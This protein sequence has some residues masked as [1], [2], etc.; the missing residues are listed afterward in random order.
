MSNG[1]EQRP[2]I[3]VGGIAHETHCFA[4][5]L[6]D[7]DDFRKQALFFGDDIPGQLAATK[8]ATAGMFANARAD[9]EIIPT[10]YAGALPA[11]VVTTDAFETILGEL[12]TRLSAAMPLEGVLLALHGAMVTEDE[13]DAES[14]ILAD[15]RGVVGPDVPVV[16]VLD[17]HGN[18]SPRTV[19]L[20]EVEPGSHLA[21]L[22]ARHR[23]RLAIDPEVAEEC[24]LYKRI[25]LDLVFRSR[26]L[27]QLDR[28]S[29]YILTR[30][31]GVFAELY[32]V[33]EKPGRG[34]YHLLAEEE[35]KLVFSQP[36]EASRARV[37][38]DVLAKMTDGIA[39][40]TYRRLFDAD[41]GS[42]VDL[43]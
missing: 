20:A 29:D 23:F 30:L 27:Q 26:Q 5:R 8:S 19:E 36:D 6:T 43:V 37:V 41:F 15:V 28:K 22:S 21:D 9:W 32:I 24:A 39:S 40:R 1:T 31:F 17:M 12:R 2:R 3:A 34:H 10:V 11:G 35:E 38:C 13:L 33:P 16:I 4:T 14:R 25:A 18:I 42:I 7:L